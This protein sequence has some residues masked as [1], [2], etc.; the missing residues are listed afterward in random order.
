MEA[1]TT[2]ACSISG[3]ETSS[4]VD[5]EL[6]SIEAMAAGSFSISG[7]ETSSDDDEEIC[8]KLQFHLH[9][10]LPSLE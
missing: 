2:G 1:Q 8:L 5:E 10:A 7:D 4:D 9:R 3:D 6:A